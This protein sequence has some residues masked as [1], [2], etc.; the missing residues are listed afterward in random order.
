MEAF[1]R[2]LLV[3]SNLDH[4]NVLN[5]IG[6]QHNSEQGILWFIS[7]FMVEGNVKK[8]LKKLNPSM[9][10]RLSLVGGVSNIFM[11]QLTPK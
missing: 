2:E 6:W 8:Y 10:I 3:W 7:P 1:A 4:D 9:P 11:Y 5:L